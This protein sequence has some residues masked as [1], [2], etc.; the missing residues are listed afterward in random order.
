MQGATLL[1]KTEVLEVAVGEG[2]MDIGTLKWW[3]LAAL[4]G[5]PL[6]RGKYR[7]KTIRAC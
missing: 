3:P 1:S 5:W 7:E 6:V 2:N 4:E